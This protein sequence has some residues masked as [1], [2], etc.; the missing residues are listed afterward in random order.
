MKVQTSETVFL[1]SGETSPA[2]AVGSLHPHSLQ[3]SGLKWEKLKGQLSLCTPTVGKGS[4]WP[5][6]R[7]RRPGGRGSAPPWFPSGVAI[8]KSP[9]LLYLASPRSQTLGFGYFCLRYPGVNLPVA[10]R[11]S[12]IGP[13]TS[14]GQAFASL[15]GKRELSGSRDWQLRVR[16]RSAVPST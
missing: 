9:A 15:S 13:S 14:L 2:L 3:S 16:L 7:Q 6:H 10:S 5:P 8:G 4:S 1:R 11:I 12:N